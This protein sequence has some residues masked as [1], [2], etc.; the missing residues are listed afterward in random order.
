MKLFPH[1]RDCDRFV[2]QVRFQSQGWRSGR[3][4]LKYPCQQHL[5][6][7][8]H[9]R[10]LASCRELSTQFCL[11]SSQGRA[12]GAPA[13]R[14]GELRVQ[15]VPSRGSLSLL[16]GC[17][18]ALSHGAPKSS[19]R[20]ELR[21]RGG[22]RAR[23]RRRDAEEEEKHPLSQNVIQITPY[24]TWPLSRAWGRGSFQTPEPL[25]SYTLAS[26]NAMMYGSLLSPPIST[27]SS[28]NPTPVQK[29]EL[30]RAGEWKIPE[31]PFCSLGMANTFIL[32]GSR[33]K[34]SFS[35]WFC[36]HFQS[37]IYFILHDCPRV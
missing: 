33:E 16:Q 32:L 37:V 27:D 13:R 35:P 29:A 9:W 6:P 34:P 31:N 20:A 1:L 19:L 24:I 7:F 12:A 22:R 26:E 14:C 23:L 15:W 10:V 3:Y 21:Q 36:C 4:L 5:L 18:P 30:L 11:R 25:K 28:K 2:F 8:V 17:G